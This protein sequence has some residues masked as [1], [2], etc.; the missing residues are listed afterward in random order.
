M[1]VKYHCPE[2]QAKQDT[3]KLLVNSSDR[4]LTH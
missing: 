1:R 4:K 2:V 3:H